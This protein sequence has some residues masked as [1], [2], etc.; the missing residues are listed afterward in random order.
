MMHYE[1][2]LQK[3]KGRF[4]FLLCEHDDICAIFKKFFK[5]QHCIATEEWVPVPQGWVRNYKACMFQ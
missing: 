4:G 2:E 1:P 5:K 3:I